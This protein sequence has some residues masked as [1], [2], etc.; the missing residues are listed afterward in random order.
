MN[1]T[2]ELCHV[3]L[4]SKWSPPDY[5]HKSSQTQLAFFLGLQTK[6]QPNLFVRFKTK[7]EDSSSSQALASSKNNEIMV[8][9]DICW[10]ICGSYTKI[11]EWC[12]IRYTNA[13]YIFHTFE[14]NY[15]G[16]LKLSLFAILEQVFLFQHQKLA[17]EPNLALL[18]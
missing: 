2:I 9:V 6:I 12:I 1:Y 16:Y 13:W 18:I 10:Y 17:C 7:D 8:W 14:I 3:K 5:Y 4:A 15:R 11:V